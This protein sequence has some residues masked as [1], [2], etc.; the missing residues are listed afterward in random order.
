MRSTVMRTAVALCLVAL[1]GA[2]QAAVS[3]DA[4]LMRSTSDLVALCTAAPSDPMGTAALN[5]CHGFGVGVYRVL[6]EIEMTRGNHL[7]CMP[8]TLPTRNESLASFIRWASSNP[9]AL[10]TPPQD[11]IAM[12]L[13]KQ[14]PCANKK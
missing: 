14:Y 11:G 4:F 1:P 12:F 6:E 7:F 9:E 10:S 13:S 3:E 5:F 8:A 2:G